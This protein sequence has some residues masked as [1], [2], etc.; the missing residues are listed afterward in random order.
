MVLSPGDILHKRY[1]IV[2]KLASSKYG[3][4]YRGW[5]IAEKNQVA[6]KEML[7]T[8]PAVAR[9]FRG[10]VRKFSSIKHPNIPTVRDQ[11]VL[12]E[13]IHYMV[14]DFIEGLKEVLCLILYI[15]KGE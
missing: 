1:R 8:D 3:A 12:D 9:K 11:F 4:M 6:I 2:G 13:V 5:D 15:F 10:E 7:L 14:T